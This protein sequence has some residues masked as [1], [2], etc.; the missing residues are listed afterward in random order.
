VRAVLTPLKTA[1]DSGPL[2]AFPLFLADEEDEF[3]IKR[4]FAPKTPPRIQIEITDAD[5]TWKW[6]AKQC[7]SQGKFVALAL[8]ILDGERALE[9]DYS[10]AEA[11]QQVF[12][13]REVPRALELR[14]LRTPRAIK[15]VKTSSAINISARFTLAAIAIAIAVVGSLVFAMRKH[16][17]PIAIAMRTATIIEVPSI[18]LP[19]IAVAEATGKIVPTINGHRLYIDG[20]LVGDSKG[21]LD[22]PCGEHSVKLGS[23]GFTKTVAVPCGGEVS[24]SP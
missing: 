11:T 9:F 19:A 10:E 5:A 2:P 22:V 14:R 8:P 7:D 20:K 13:M 12:A 21:P 16:N 3:T 6:E 15:P 23:A 17:A 4:S 24:V 18:D 1:E